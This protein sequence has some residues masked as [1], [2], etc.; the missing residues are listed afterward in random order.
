MSDLGLVHRGEQVNL[1][2]Q[3]GKDRHLQ[4]LHVFELDYL[5]T[6]ILSVKF[7][8]LKC[9][10]FMCWGPVHIELYFDFNWIPASVQ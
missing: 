1:G 10:Q 2:V 3:G 9:Y 6:H 4:C 8:T 5:K 7:E